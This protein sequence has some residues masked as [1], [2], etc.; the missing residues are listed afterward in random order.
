MDITRK[1]NRIRPYIKHGDL[2][3]FH[4]RGLVASV[5]QSCDRSYWNHVG[6][7]LKVNGALFIVDANATGVQADRLSWRIKKYKGGDFSVIQS[8]IERSLIDQHLSDLLSISDEKWIKYDF[9]NGIK[10]LLNRKFGWKLNIEEDASHDICSDYVKLYA[11]E[12]KMVTDSFKHLKIA[13]PEDYF[14][15]LNYENSVLLK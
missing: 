6:V 7:V 1:Y 3:L 2:I 5:I 12:T 14:R 4:G 15:F 11:M 10:E 9:M 8:G 13:F